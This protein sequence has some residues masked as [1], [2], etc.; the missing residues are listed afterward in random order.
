MVTV[1]DVKPGDLIEEVAKE[2]KEKEL[3]KAPEWSPFVKTGSHKDRPPTQED[4][5]YLRCAAILR[6]LYKKGPLGVGTLRILY[7]GRKN[8]GHKT[9][10]FRKAG[11]KIIR[12]ALQQLENAELVR[13]AEKRKGRKLTSKGISF[14]DNIALKISK[15]ESK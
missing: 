7:G 6:K 10:H 9:E 15:N 2:L 4:W 13:T 14:L 5:Y 11:G 3:V 8:K 12:S 1:Y